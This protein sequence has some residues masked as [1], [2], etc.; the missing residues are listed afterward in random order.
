[1]IPEAQDYLGEAREDLRE[2][3]LIA[4]RLPAISAAP[5]QTQ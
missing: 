1:M 4:S 3:W 5:S 2:A